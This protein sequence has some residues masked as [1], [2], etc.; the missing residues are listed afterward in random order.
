MKSHS[1]QIIVIVYFN[2]NFSK[3]AIWVFV[4]PR[5]CELLSLATQHTLEQRTM[6]KFSGDRKKTSHTHQTLEQLKSGFWRAYS[7]TR[8][9]ESTLT[10]FGVQIYSIQFMNQV[11]T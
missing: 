8:I 2:L 11:K 3:M 9:L 10:A 6:T 1:P 4:K 5:M 7:G